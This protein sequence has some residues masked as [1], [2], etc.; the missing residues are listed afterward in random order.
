MC[1]CLRSYL[2]D[3]PAVAVEGTQ[4]LAAA[5]QPPHRPAGGDRGRGGAAGRGKCGQRGR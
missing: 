3:V 5:A 1:M 2:A 4:V